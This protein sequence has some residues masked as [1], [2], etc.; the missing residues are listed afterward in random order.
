MSGKREDL[1]RTDAFKRNVAL[2]DLLKELNSLLSC[3]ENMFLSKN[4]SDKLDYPL[5]FVMGPLRSGTT[6]LMQWLAN[7]GLVAYPTNLLSRFYGV[8]VTGAHIQL[9]LTDPRYNFRNEIL[10]FNS[11]ISFESKN[12]KTQG[13]MAPNEFWYF[14]RR[15]LPFSDLDWVPDDELLRV[16]DKEMLI[17]ELTALTRVFCKP[18]AL[19]GMILNYN[20]SFLDAIFE[21]AIFIQI[22]RD[23]VTNTASILD[24]RKRQV[25]SDKEWYSFRIPEYHQLKE[26]DP[27]V[28][29]AGQVYFINKA[30]T[31]GMSKI[32]ERRKV[33]IHY[34]SF[35]G[36]PSALFEELTYKL[37]L[38]M[39]KYTG[40]KAF[41]VTRNNEFPEKAAIEQALERFRGS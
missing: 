26:L 1:T 21:K 13:A 24:A 34:E 33:V 12:G 27:L 11:D 10:D 17:A 32:N 19:K 35:C 2:E 3:S 20:I 16:V 6:L 39:Q 18:F 8:P 14:W 23:P 25:G 36:N 9:L 37:D 30:V 28:Q 15:F 41:S 5:V 38:P 31:A 4:Y 7:S 22:K 40:P 29:S